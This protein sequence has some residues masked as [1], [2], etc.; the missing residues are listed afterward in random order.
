MSLEL[1]RALRMQRQKPA[2]VVSIILTNKP[3]SVDDSPALVVIK[4]T[5]E[6]QFMDLRPLVGLAVAV[7]S[8]DASP[9]QFLRLLDALE[10][11]KCKFFGAV[12]EDFVLPMLKDAT[13]KHAEL[14]SRSW[15]TLC[16]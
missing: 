13:P 14:L 6:P 12:T 11:L 8:R 2:G 16:Q 15:S 4:P 3:L 7:Y 10:A 9:D 5:D 1:L